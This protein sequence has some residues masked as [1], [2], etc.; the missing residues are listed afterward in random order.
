LSRNIDSVLSDMAFQECPHSSQQCVN[1]LQVQAQP[2]TSS[3]VQPN[4]QSV[5]EQQVIGESMSTSRRSVR[6]KRDIDSVLSDM[7]FQACPDSPQQSGDESHVQPVPSSSVQPDKQSVSEQQVAEERRST[8]RR[9]VRLSRN[10]DSVLSDMAFQECSYRPQQSVDA[11]QSHVQPV[12]SAVQPGK[13]SVLEQQ[14]TGESISTLR[15]SVRLKRDIDSVL[16]DIAFQECPHSSQQSAD[17]LES[18]VHSVTSSSAQPA[19]QSVSEQQATE[20]G[21]GTSR[22]SV[23]LNRH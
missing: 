23:R 5:S 12:T 22:R 21:K 14:V 3:S 7:A 20:E 13:Q 10:I 19:E 11:L 8:S 4:K 16:S 17:A 18:H 2:V 15:R 1:T 6:L 9:R